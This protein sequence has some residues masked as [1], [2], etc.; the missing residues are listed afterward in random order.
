MW[1]NAFCQTLELRFPDPAGAFAR[2]FGRR[3]QRILV[4]ASGAWS[5]GLADGR[6][7]DASLRAGW[8]AAGGRAVG[9]SWMGDDR[10]RYA[11]M[12]LCTRPEQRPWR[13]LL[14][15]LRVPMT[16]QLS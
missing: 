9:L 14:V 6:T 4:H 13:R 8:I 10:R 11:C 16:T 12:I 5:L 15:R 3:I 7:V 1:S 2:P